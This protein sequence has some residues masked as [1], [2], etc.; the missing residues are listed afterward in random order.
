[1]SKRLEWD[2]TGTKRYQTGTKMGVLYPQGTDGNYEAGVAWNG[3]TG[4]NEAPSGAEESA[5][6][7]DDIKYLSLSS[8]EEFGGTIT[9]YDTPPEFDECDGTSEIATGV[10]VG[11]QERKGFGFCY[12]TILG[13]DVKRNKAGYKIHVVYG[14]HAKPSSI[15]YKS[16]NE[17]TEAI[18]LSYE[19]TTTPVS[20]SGMDP[21]ATLVIDSTKA[22]PEKLKKLEDIL[23]GSAEADARLPLPDEIASI[24]KND[25]TPSP[26]PGETTDT[27]S[28]KESNSEGKNSGI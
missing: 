5:I 12:R 9:A 18:E 13:N 6:Y 8:I 20:V 15:D 4:V 28:G 21:T 16:V 22:D 10:T 14:A 25:T 1:M 27:E 3:L 2:Q 26:K 19:F 11:Q 7:A 17:N 24:M 23:Y